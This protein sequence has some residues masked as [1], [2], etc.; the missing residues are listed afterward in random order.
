MAG[1]GE[2]DRQDPYNSR[3]WSERTSLPRVIMTKDGRKVASE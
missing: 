2:R 1:E 3:S